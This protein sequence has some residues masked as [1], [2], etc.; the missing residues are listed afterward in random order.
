MAMTTLDHLDNIAV[1]G[2]VFQMPTNEYW[3]LVCLKDGLEFIF[4]QV[5]KCDE[6]ARQRPN[7]EGKLKVLSMGN[8]PLLAEFPKGLLTC[9]FHWYAVT[10]C[11]YV[12]TVGAIA[13]QHDSKRPLPT[14]YVRNVIPEVLA[15]R[16]KVAAHFAWTMKN[17]HDCEAD[18]KLSVMPQLR[19]QDD[20]CHVGGWNLTVK[21]SPET[22]TS[23]AIVAWSVADVHER[24]RKR[25]WPEQEPGA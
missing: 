1:P 14:Q 9:S 2:D 22:S 12:R 16:D 3:A 24:L 5:R 10:A 18:R 20:A 6:L 19:F 21:S 7:P 13:R 23:K 11:Q 4:R 15:F 17:K 25:Y 8:D